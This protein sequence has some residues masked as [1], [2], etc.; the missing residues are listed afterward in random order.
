MKAADRNKDGGIQFEEF[1]EIPENAGNPEDD[2]I[3]MTTPQGVDVTSSNVTSSPAAGRDRLHGDLSF[4]K[5][6]PKDPPSAP[7][8]RVDTATCLPF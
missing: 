5:L 7:K 6:A 8:E 3:S 2:A 4:P 1:C